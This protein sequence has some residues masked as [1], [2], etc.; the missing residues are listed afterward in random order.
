M[1]YNWPK[2]MNTNEEISELVFLSDTTENSMCR[3]DE[4][5]ECCG[6]HWYDCIR[7]NG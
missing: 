5:D 6:D 4:V 7:D 3:A 1:G 2:K